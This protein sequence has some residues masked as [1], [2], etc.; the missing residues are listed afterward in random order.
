MRVAVF[1]T[2]PYDQT[3]L[4][5]ANAGQYELVFL[6]LHLDVLTAQLAIGCQAVCAFVNDDLSAPVLEVL[7]EFGVQL[8]AL[9]CAGFNQVD[10]KA[11]QR[12][13]LITL[14]VPAY[15]PHAVAEHALALL[16]TLNRQIHRAYNRV[17]DGNFALDGLLG[18]DL[19]KKT[20]GVIGTG[21][22]GAI[23]AKLLHAF[24]CRVLAFDLFPNP[25]LGFLE[26]L[27]LEQVFAESDVISLHCPLTPQTQHMVSATRLAQMK[28]GAMLVNTSR[29]ALIDTPAVLDALKTGHLGALALD[30]YEEEA[31]LFFENLSNQVIQDD[32]FMRLLTFP[33]VL[34]TGHQ[35]FFTKEALEQ[36]AK[37]TIENIQAFVTKRPL[38][39]QCLADS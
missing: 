35:G 26:Y 20:I 3:F 7:A 19:H 29:G 9:R 2:K 18:F 13:G 12:L 11:A 14:R 1:N 16:L 6:E 38:I 31:D 10:L 27:P 39:N 5:A 25:S 32:V 33:N 4:T 28:R 24:D 15:S 23:F 36:I 30:V 22:I 17:R 21:K 34:I 8:I 37:T